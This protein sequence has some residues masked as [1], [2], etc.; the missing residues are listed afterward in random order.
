MFISKLPDPGIFAI[1][2]LREK[3]VLPLGSNVFQNYVLVNLDGLVSKDGIRNL[4][5]YRMQ[6]LI[7][8]IVSLF[9]PRFPKLAT[10]LNSFIV[11]FFGLNKYQTTKFEISTPPEPILFVADW[12]NSKVRLCE[13]MVGGGAQTC[14]VDIH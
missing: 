5:A 8:K 12:E 14:S 4:K 1:I 2:G 9:C 6:R 7:F 11:R 10:F 3:G 13:V